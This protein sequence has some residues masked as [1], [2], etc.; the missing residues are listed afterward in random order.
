VE[1]I[2]NQGGKEIREVIDREINEKSHEKVG[3][4]VLRKLGFWIEDNLLGVS[5]GFVFLIFI[6][7]F[8][9]LVKDNIEAIKK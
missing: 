7:I 5:I 4:V 8:I 1:V 9:Y 2:A 6:V 3:K